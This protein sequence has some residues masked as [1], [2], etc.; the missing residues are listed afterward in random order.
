MRALRS[1]DVVLFA[2]DSVTAAGRDPADARDP[3][4]GYAA[5]V[6][7]KLPGVRGVNGGVSG[8]TVRQLEERLPH[9]L[10]ATRP[11]VVSVLIGVN[12]VCR[13]F[14]GLPHS[15]PL[16]FAT[17]YRRII[18]LARGDGPVPRRVLLLEPFLLPVKPDLAPWR[19]VLDALLAVVR[20][21]AAATRV[22]LVRLDALFNDAARR[23]DAGFWL[24]DGVHPSAP[25]HGLIA[26]AWLK[27]FG[28]IDPAA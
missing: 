6:M 25:G 24:P 17:A 12:D 14:E 13:R 5:R 3:G 15:D 22:P 26:D 7:E 21:T 20:E 11:T 2:G 9:L 16:E 4:N 28:T 18:A 27:V 1:D 8:D 19:G 23:E 10:A